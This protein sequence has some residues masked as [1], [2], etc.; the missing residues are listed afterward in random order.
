MTAFTVMLLI[1]VL[2]SVS[3]YIYNFGTSCHKYSLPY[4]LMSYHPKAKQ[5]MDYMNQ[6]IYY[7]L[8]PDVFDPL[9]EYNIAQ[10]RLR[11]LCVISSQKGYISPHQLKKYVYKMRIFHD[12]YWSSS[13]YK[14]RCQECLE[15]HWINASSKLNLLDDDLYNEFAK[16]I[17]FEYSSR[18]MDN[19][20]YVLS[21]KELSLEF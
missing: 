19:N 15:R 7:A 11:G 14:Y 16:G 1:G 2:S 10:S 4:L 9:T 6:L 3:F 21:K 8:T 12:N 20:S 17:E 5:N 13:Y 18:Y